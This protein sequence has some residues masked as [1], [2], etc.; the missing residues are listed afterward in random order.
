MDDSHLLARIIGISFIT[1]Y[2][3]V[4][5]NK[6]FFFRIWQD[7]SSHPILLLFSGL[8]QLVFGLI[9]VNIHPIWH[10]NWQGLITFLGW[11]F[12]AGGISRILLPEFIIQLSKKLMKNEVILSISAAF[13]L[14][15]GIYLTYIGFN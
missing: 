7:L 1:I 9:I 3:S 10:A 2:S 12:L 5:L 11:L 15:I 8:L 14:L 13:M 6:K 4:L